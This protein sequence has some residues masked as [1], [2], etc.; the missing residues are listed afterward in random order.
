MK[1]HSKNLKPRLGYKMDYAP[2]AKYNDQDVF[3]IEEEGK[4][5]ISI[6][7]LAH[8]YW[9]KALTNIT[10]ENPDYEFV[11]QDDIVVNM[12]EFAP[13]IERINLLV[14]SL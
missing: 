7:S 11:T 2:V 1:S 8:R 6:G 5:Y 13:I 10:R 9:L 3:L 12:K 14:Q 4:W